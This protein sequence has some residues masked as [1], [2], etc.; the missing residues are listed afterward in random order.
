MNA[1]P[2]S[3]SRWI[4]WARPLA[5]FLR[6]APRTRLECVRFSVGRGASFAQAKSVSPWLELEGL[7][8]AE[9]GRVSLTP[10][11]IAWVG[12]ERVELVLLPAA[13]RPTRKPRGVPPTPPSWSRLRP[14]ERAGRSV[15]GYALW[16]CACA[17]GGSCVV[18]AKHLRS[19]NTTSCGCVLAELRASGRPSSQWR[20]AS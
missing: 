19:G 6:V 11:G 12:D 7:A 17:C 1:P 9:A 13:E 3:D 15:D 20:V 18:M 4:G 10:E 5:A 14:V 2:S 16:R 8:R